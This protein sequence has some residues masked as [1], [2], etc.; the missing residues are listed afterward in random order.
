M[1]LNTGHL[2]W[3]SSPLTTR[4]FL[5][6][7]LLHRLGQVCDVLWESSIYFAYFSIIL[8]NVRFTDN[9]CFIENKTVTTRNY[10]RTGKGIYSYNVV[11]NFLIKLRQLQSSAFVVH[12]L[13]WQRGIPKGSSSNEL[14]SLWSFICHIADKFSLVS[15]SKSK[16]FT[17]VAI[18]LL[19]S[20]PICTG[21]LCLTWIARVLYW[22]NE[23][24]L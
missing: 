4:P 8:A 1:V 16:F 19:V 22:A 2:D 15:L 9:A 23:N 13:A 3:E 11:H 5:Y 14:L 21:T 24:V 12:I 20:H 10:A 18:A 6:R 7:T 17:H